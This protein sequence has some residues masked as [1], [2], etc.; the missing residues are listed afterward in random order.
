MR[1]YRSGV[2]L[3]ISM[4][5]EPEFIA[6]TLAERV[7]TTCITLDHIQIEKPRHDAYIERFNRAY[8]TK[9]LN[10]YVSDSLQ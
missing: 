7:K 6:H 5:N 1:W 9:V 4:G 2:H 8:R 3:S 10:F